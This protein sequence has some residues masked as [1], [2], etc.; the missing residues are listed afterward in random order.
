MLKVML[1]ILTLTSCA[2]RL[3]SWA[4]EVPQMYKC[5]YMPE[6]SKFRCTDNKT[7]K[8]FNV[9]LDDPGMAKAQCTPLDHYL[10]GEKWIDDFASAAVQHCN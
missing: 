7:N 9:P 2:T 8:S 4:P 3:P 10:K 5:T 6:F 1:F